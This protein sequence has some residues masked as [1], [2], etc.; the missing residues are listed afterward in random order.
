MDLCSECLAL[1]REDARA[2]R[3][4][5]CDWC[6]T[7]ATDLSDTRDYDEGMYGPVYQVCGGCRKRRDDALR[8]ELDRYEPLD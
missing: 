5:V 7:S 8:E 6:S 3:V 4:G 2:A 1:D